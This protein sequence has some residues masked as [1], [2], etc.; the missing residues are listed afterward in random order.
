[1]NKTLITLLCLLALL[2]SF[3]P[4]YVPTPDEVEKFYSTKT[5]VPFLKTRVKGSDPVDIVVHQNGVLNIIHD[6]FLIY[7]IPMVTR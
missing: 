7:F 4:D 5:L 1:M 3:S 6:K 2:T